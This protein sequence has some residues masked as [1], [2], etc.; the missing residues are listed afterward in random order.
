MNDYFADLYQNL[1]HFNKELDILKVS[2]GNN[3]SSEEAM[4]SLVL[5]S[6]NEMRTESPIYSDSESARARTEDEMIAYITERI[7]QIFKG[8]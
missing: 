2:L 4:Q 7:G 1:T 6:Q 5:S 8:K 3:S